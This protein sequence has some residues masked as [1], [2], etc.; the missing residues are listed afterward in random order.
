MAV[1]LFT[2]GMC[3]AM[4]VVI[5]VSGSGVNQT[6]ITSKSQLNSLLQRMKMLDEVVKEKKGVDRLS[7]SLSESIKQQ[8]KGD[9][10]KAKA[11]KIASVV[12]NTPYDT[13]VYSDEA[14]IMSIIG[15]VSPVL[16]QFGQE[17]NLSSADLLKYATL[18]Q[19]YHI[20]PPV[21]AHLVKNHYGQA[22]VTPHGHEV[23]GYEKIKQNG[24]D[25][26]TL[27]MLK[28]F[29]HLSDNAQG[30][31][32]PT[33]LGAAHMDILNNTITGQ[34]DTIYKGKWGF[35]IH[36][37]ITL[38]VGAG[39]LIQSQVQVNAAIPVNGTVV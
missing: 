16:F 35:V 18:L 34:Q 36:A 32:Q 14:K 8:N 9:K 19:E 5:P 38:M 22:G 1:I 33:P 37:I 17:H 7:E 25:Q 23:K 4:D 29:K 13:N 30:I 6:N 26:Y 12:K 31:Q 28:I 15:Q 20:D 24:G 2:C 39:W 21:M 3:Y 27:T 11:T 10:G